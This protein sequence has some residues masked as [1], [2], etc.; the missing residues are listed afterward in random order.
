MLVAG[1]DILAERLPVDASGRDLRA[2]TITVARS[3][4]EPFR[5]TDHIGPTD[6]HARDRHDL[7]RRAR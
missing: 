2:V 5:L 6:R 4:R 3:E 7:H 1:F